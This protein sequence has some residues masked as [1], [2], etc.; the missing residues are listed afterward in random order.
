VRL[1]SA[2]GNADSALPVVLATTNGGNPVAHVVW[3]D[4]RAGVNGDIYYR[5]IR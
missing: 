1:D 2:T 4:R 3:V 5:S